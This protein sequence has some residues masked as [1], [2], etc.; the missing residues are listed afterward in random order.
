MFQIS[1]WAYLLTFPLF[2]YAWP[3]LRLSPRRVTTSCYVN[4][5]IFEMHPESNR[6]SIIREI[7]ELISAD[8]LKLRSYVITAMKQPAILMASFRYGHQTL[9]ELGALLSKLPVSEL[10]ALF[11]A[12]PL[13]PDDFGVL[14]RSCP[15][16]LMLLATTAAK[17]R[18]VAMMD[19]CFD[20]LLLKPDG[21][22]SELR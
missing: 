7:L 1:S 2:L 8:E 16:L 15:S 10:G 3:L 18:L 19:A 11:G 21:I 22:R 13:K 6:G 17:F 14:L 12:S 9:P 4:P 20:Q 5:S